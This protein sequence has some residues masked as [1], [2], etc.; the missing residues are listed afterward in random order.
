MNTPQQTPSNIRP[1]GARLREKF[2]QL[3][4]ERDSANRAAESAK[5]RADGLD[6][7]V[8]RLNGVIEDKGKDAAKEHDKTKHQLKQSEARIEWLLKQ[9]NV[10]AESGEYSFPDGTKYKVPVPRIPAK[11]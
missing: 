10:T 1:R 7:E 3:I 8:K 6:L 9:L 2:P 11:K 5:I 4:A